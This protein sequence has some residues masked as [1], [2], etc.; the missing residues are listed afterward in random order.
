MKLQVHQ[1]SSPS[2]ACSMTVQDQHMASVAEAT[3]SNRC[4]AWDSLGYHIRYSA[5]PTKQ[6]VCEANQNHYIPHSKCTYKQCTR[7]EHRVTIQRGSASLT[8]CVKMTEDGMSQ[9]HQAGRITVTVTVT[10]LSCEGQGLGKRLSRS[11]L[12]RCLI[13]AGE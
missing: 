2:S 5:G 11:P 7:C 4:A 13:G 9:E 10:G 3:C 12:D 8:E 1:K 6:T